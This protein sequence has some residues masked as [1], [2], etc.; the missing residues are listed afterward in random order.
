MTQFVKEQF[1][2]DREYVHYNGKFVA[3]FKHMPGSK[4]SFVAFLIKN[5]SVE[6]YF[7]AMTSGLAPLQIVNDKGYI[8]PHIKKWLKEAGLPLTREGVKMLLNKSF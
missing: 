4:K 3:R 7:A 6:E 2:I 1:A 5:F 8:Q